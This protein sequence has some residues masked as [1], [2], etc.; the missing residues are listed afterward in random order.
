MNTPKSYCQDVKP[1]VLLWWAG[2]GAIF[3]SLIGFIFDPSARMLSYQVVEIPYKNWIA[4]FAIALLGLL[5]K[6]MYIV[7]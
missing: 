1:I 5:G 7:I 6:I 4:Y 3:F 2:I